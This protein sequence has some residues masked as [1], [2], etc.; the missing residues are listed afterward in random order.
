M[1]NRHPST[2]KFGRN[3]VITGHFR[4]LFLICGF[5]SL[6]AVGQAVR[7]IPT[8]AGEGSGQSFL[9]LGN[10]GR[11][12]LSWIDRLESK[13]FA[14][15]FSV[16]EKTGWSAAR[17]IVEGTNWF[18]NWADFPSLVELPDGS[19]AAHWL[20]RSGPGVY[21]YDVNVSRSF[22]GG[23]N[24]SPPM[25]PHRDGTQTEHG[26]VSMF[27]AGSRALAVVWL[28]GREMKAVEGGHAH[29]EMALRFA[30]VGRDG[31]ISQERVLDGRVCECCQ[32]SAAM[33]STGPIVVYRDRSAGEIRDISI[34]RLINGHEWTQPTTVHAD[35][36]KI[37]GC[38]VNG[39]SVA[40]NG[41]RV[42]VAWF[43]M[44]GGAPRVKVSF[45]RDAGATFASP[46]EVADVDPVGRVDTVM[47]DDE[48][49][50]VS[51][52]ERTASGADLRVRRVW[53]NGALA[54]A[55]TVAPSGTARSS[56]FPQMVRADQ[57]ILF[58]WTGK[59]RIQT[60]EMLVPKEWR[61]GSKAREGS[62]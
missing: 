22:D 50:L 37:D 1:D 35:N 19:L 7:E 3:L 10:H 21:A 58:S 17:T 53:P 6:S 12:Y 40:A 28:D 48:S 20:A 2:T 29:G 32:T 46:I 15:R 27:G 57:R 45:S 23:K 54:P 13:R 56:G 24:W 36:W 62:R 5:L 59:T 16:R 25:I 47:L 52:I 44:S 51:W 30:A 49:A 55:I 42:A 31:N 14:L 8:P 11:V 26:F 61:T 60:A 18:V 4:A 34:V 33:T 9:S 43:S 38:P 39:P 41:L